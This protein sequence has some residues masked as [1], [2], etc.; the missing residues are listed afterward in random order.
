V[1]EQTPEKKPLF[2]EVQL[3]AYT[4]KEFLRFYQEY[5]E[6]L[7][8]T[9][10]DLDDEL[11]EKMVMTPEQA[12]AIKTAGEEAYDRSAWLKIYYKKRFPHIPTS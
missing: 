11:R 12:D 1:T 4:D 3:D 7:R 6:H 2:S 5:M 9:I 10:M 8:N